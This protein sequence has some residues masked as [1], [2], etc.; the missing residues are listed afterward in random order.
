MSQASDDLIWDLINNQCSFKI[1]TPQKDGFCRNEYNVTGVCSRGT[2]PLANSRY[3]TVRNI[4]GR[5]Y[6]YV[7][8]P[9]RVH[10]PS[11]WWERV[12]LSHSYDKALAQIDR[13]L[14]YWPAPLIDKNKQRLTRLFQVL[15][16]ERRLAQTTEERHLES[17][18]PKV[19]R[20]ERDRERK[21]LVAAKIERA[22][23]KELLDRL[24]SGAY[25]DQP[26]NV[27]EKVWSKVLQGVEDTE[28]QKESEGES[29][30]EAEDEVEYVEDDDEDM[31]DMEDLEKWLEN[32]PRSQEGGAFTSESSDDDSDDKERPT[33]RPRRGAHVEIEYE[34]N[35]GTETAR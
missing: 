1:V 28:V 22:I 32:S 6:L 5:M 11:K 9:E 20:R 25:G 3:S 23:E 15:M 27:D 14:A 26:L 17:V 8:E 29:E 34:N 33:K 19:R 10:L 7:K 4:D 30:S 13:H 16:T 18:A 24:K 31:E 35:N 21:A 2:C 12:K